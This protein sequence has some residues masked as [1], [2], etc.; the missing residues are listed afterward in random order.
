MGNGRHGGVHGLFQA[1]PVTTRV[2]MASGETDVAP[3]PAP[4]P[5]AVPTP[6]QGWTAVDK[7]VLGAWG[8]FLAMTKGTPSARPSD[9]EALALFWQADRIGVYEGPADGTAVVWRIDMGD[10]TTAAQVASMLQGLPSVTVRTTGS[11]AVVARSSEEELPE[12]AFAM[13]AE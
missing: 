11:W 4:E 2:L 10:A 6:P 1:P 8:L 7:D 9:L 12:W 13:N 5:P 3:M